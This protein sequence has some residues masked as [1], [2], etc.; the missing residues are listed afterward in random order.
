MSGGS[1]HQL[2]RLKSIMNEHFESKHIMME[3]P[4]LDKSPVAEKI[5]WQDDGISYIPDK[6]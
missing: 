5:V 3:R 1:K 2:D 6:L 4:D